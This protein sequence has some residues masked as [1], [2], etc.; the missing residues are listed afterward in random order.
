MF[1]G[2]LSKLKKDLV[3]ID[4]GLVYLKLLAT[5]IWIGDEEVRR[6]NSGEQFIWMERVNCTTDIQAAKGQRLVTSNV[7]QHRGSLCLLCQQANQP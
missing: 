4:A 7:S 6:V 3:V 5:E 1:A 2:V